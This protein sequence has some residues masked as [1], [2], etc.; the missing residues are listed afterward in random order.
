MDDVVVTSS[1]TDDGRGGGDVYGK[2]VALRGG[3]SWREERLSPAIEYCREGWVVFAVLE[4]EEEEEEEVIDFCC[5]SFGVFFWLS[6]PESHFRSRRAEK[7]F[8][9]GGRL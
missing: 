1:V 8:T 7:R 5:W 2:L 4:D 9:R 6:A 3:W